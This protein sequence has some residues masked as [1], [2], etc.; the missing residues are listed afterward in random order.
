MA[1]CLIIAHIVQII[2]QLFLIIWGVVF[3]DVV[4]VYLFDII[5]VGFYL[6]SLT[7]AGDSLD[8]GKT[9]VLYKGFLSLR[10]IIQTL[11][12]LC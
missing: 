12:K 4:G 8:L 2:Y 11:R 9:L 3:P 1:S 5:D 7:L 6:A 10:I